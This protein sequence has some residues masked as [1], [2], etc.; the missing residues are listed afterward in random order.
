[1]GNFSGTMNQDELESLAKMTGSSQEDIQ[2]M[3]SNFVKLDRDQKGYVTKK[4]VIDRLGIS[5]NEEKIFM[6][7]LLD[8]FGDKTADNRI[9]FY[10]FI[11]AI[12]DFKSDSKDKKLKILFNLIDTDQNGLLGVKEIE[13][14]FRMVKLEHLTKQDIAEIAYQTLL[15][16]DNDQDGHLDFEEFK[17]FYNTVLQIT[18]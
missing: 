3:H 2:L 17:E 9:N 14:A 7:K 12:S 4:D 18:I 16:A 10:E 6:S 5:S 8:L 13:E 11:M 15:Y 1:M